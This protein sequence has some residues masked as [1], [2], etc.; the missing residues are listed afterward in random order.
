MIGTGLDDAVSNIVAAYGSIVD[1]R[2]KGKTPV[3]PTFIIAY[4]PPGS[5]KSTVT[6][7][8]YKNPK[9]RIREDEVVDIDVD[10]IGSAI[11]GYQEEFDGLKEGDSEGKADLYWRARKAAEPISDKVL[12]E[13]LLKN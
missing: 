2:F 6:Q 7:N 5:G 13:A 1:G 8:L 12:D 10:K 3:K 11:P 4:G 9:R